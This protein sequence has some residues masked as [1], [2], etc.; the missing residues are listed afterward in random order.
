MRRHGLPTPEE[1][2]DAPEPEAELAT[3]EEAAR[4]LRVSKSWLYA[5]AAENAV[6]HVSV[7]GRLR[8]HMP[9]LRAWLLGQCAPRGTVLPFTRTGA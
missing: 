6:P 3:V 7:L 8:F 9:T 4:F 2:V 1:L 5:K